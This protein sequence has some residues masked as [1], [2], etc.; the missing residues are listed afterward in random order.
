MFVLSWP[1]TLPGGVNEAVLGLAGALKS[2]SRF[3]PIIAVT[4]WTPWPLPQEVR[5]IP[6]IGIQLRDAYDAGLWAIAKSAARLP[7]DLRAIARTLRTHD[8]GI[9]NLHFPSLGGAAFVI[10]R[11]LGLYQGKVALTF[12]GTDVKNARASPSILRRAWRGYLNG[13]DMVFAPS[14]ALAAEVDSLSPQKRTRVIY[15]GADIDLFSRAVRTRRAGAKRILHVGRFERNKAHDVL[16]AA[17]QLVLDRGID[18]SLTMI[19]GDGPALGQVRQAAAAFGGR[20]HVHVSIPH[21]QIPEYMAAS[22]LFVLPSRSEAFGIVLLEAGAAGLPVVATAV[23]GV[24]EIITHGDTGLL[25][26]PEDPRGLAD[27]MVRILESDALA[28]S[29]AANLRVAAGRFTW[30]RAMEQFISALS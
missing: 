19:G 5:G 14:Y 21:D 30:Q 9:V 3:R 10:L 2:D 25:V 7:A 23:G 11:R 1:P 8:V 24:K 15:N 22:D 27:A 12:H 13:A 20:V 16:L 4:S 29:L 28:D 26:Q 6:V 18:C 17:F